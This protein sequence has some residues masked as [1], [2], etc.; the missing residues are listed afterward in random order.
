MVPAHGCHLKKCVRS[1]EGIVLAHWRDLARFLKGMVLL[2]LRT[3]VFTCILLRLK[4]DTVLTSSMSIHNDRHSRTKI[5]VLN[6]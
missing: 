3:F 4:V 6:E 2:H 1:R 5:I